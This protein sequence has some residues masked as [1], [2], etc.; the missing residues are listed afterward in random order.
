MVV[1]CFNMVCEVR[2]MITKDI[3]QEIVGNF[4]AEIRPNIDAWMD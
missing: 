4:G 2:T 3:S 1:V